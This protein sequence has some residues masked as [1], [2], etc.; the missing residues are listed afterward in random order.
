MT[1]PLEAELDQLFQ[2]APGELIAARNALADRLRK[3]GDRE[4]AARIKAVKRPTPGAWAINQVH[5]RHRALLERARAASEQLRQLHGQDGVELRQLQAAIEAQ[6]TAMYAVIEA[7]THCCREAGLPA[8]GALQRKLFTTLQ[9]WL[10]GGGDEAP[11]RMTHE[12]ESAGF[13]A[14]TA[15]GTPRAAEPAVAAQGASAPAAR[16]TPAS[17]EPAAPSGPDPREVA[18][19]EARVSEREQQARQAREAL[20]RARAAEAEGRLEIE[21]AQGEV[22]RAEA[23]LLERR[24]ELSARQA[25]LARLHAAAGTAEQEQR[26]ADAALARARTELAELHA[27]AGPRGGTHGP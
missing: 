4:G 22:Q 18:R 17:P 10:A 13:G 15:V 14:V 3:A 27:G 6:R 5:F 25:A 9:A 8:D 26:A 20:E 16:A 1:D 7:A 19:A 2:L 23:A 12:I 24:A 11:G 21:R